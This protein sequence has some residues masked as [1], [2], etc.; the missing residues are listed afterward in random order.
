MSTIDVKSL[1][2]AIG[3]V[4]LRMNARVADCRGQCYDGASNMSGA[5][6]GVAA[7]ITQ[8]EIW[9]LYTHCYGHALN[10]AVADTVKQLKI[11][12]NALDTA[13]E[14]TRLIKF[15]PKR[16]AAFDKIKASTP[17]DDGCPRPVGTRTLCHAWWTVRGDAI[18]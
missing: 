1:V 2:S 9:A 17:D 3:D 18:E 6:K 15:S 13:F 8:E 7:I 12:R 4:P 11:C 10:R 5:R 14:I 16:N